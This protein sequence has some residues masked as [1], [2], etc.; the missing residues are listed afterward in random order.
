MLDS[1]LKT[2]KLGFCPV[3]LQFLCKLFNKLS[4]AQMFPTSLRV[5]PGSA[6]QAKKGLRDTREMCTEYQF[7]LLAVNSHANRD[8]C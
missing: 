2:G 1:P 8:L 5:S 6:G 4:T 7:N 3:K